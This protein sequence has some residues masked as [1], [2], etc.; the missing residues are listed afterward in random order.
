MALLPRVCWGAKLIVVAGG[1]GAPAGTMR[2]S[3]PLVGPVTVTLAATARA[4][5]GTPHCPTTGKSRW[6]LAA[7]A[8]PAAPR[9]SNSRQGRRVW[10]SSG[11]AGSAL[12]QSPGPE[13]AEA[14]P[15]AAGANRQAEP[16]AEGGGA[17]TPKTAELRATL[18][19]RRVPEG[20]WVR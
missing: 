13:A 11:P 19:G 4:V 7:R 20:G 9:V 16:V 5:A 12:W 10:K 1:R 17:R 14:A 18:L 3:P 8:G 2:R 6:T 15:P